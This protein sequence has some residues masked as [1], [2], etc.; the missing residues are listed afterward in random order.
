MMTIWPDDRR[1][2]EDVGPR[3]IEE[4]KR[5]FPPRNGSSVSDEQAF[6]MLMPDGDL[7][8]DESK[9]RGYFNHSVILGS[10]NYENQNDFY[11][12]HGALRVDINK[13]LYV[14]VMFA[15][16]DAQRLAI[17][18]MFQKIGYHEMTWQ[19]VWL[20]DRTRRTDGTLQQ[21]FEALNKALSRL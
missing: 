4:I 16:T 12:Q 5:L 2:T 20:P 10:Q 7:I 19:I 8:G 3:T 21:F 18:Q 17:G 15:L 13:Y 9:W 1:P 11:K 6:Y 14:D